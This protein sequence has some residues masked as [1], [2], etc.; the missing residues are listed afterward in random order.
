MTG[1]RRNKMDN[2]TRFSK[3]APNFFNGMMELLKGAG[4]EGALS[5]KQKELSAVT[6]STVIKCVP[7]IKD[8]A[9]KALSAG[10]SR[11]EVLEA[12]AFGTVFGGAPSFVF[13]RDNLDS[14]FGILDAEG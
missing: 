4:T 2:I 13:L 9:K 5:G 3:E 11:A 6:V 1:K 14:L 12:A 10:A 7:C 8:H